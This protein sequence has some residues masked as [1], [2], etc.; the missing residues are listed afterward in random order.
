[1]LLAAIAGGAAHAVHGLGGGGHGPP[2]A[3]DGPAAARRVDARRDE[4]RQRGPVAGSRDSAASVTD[5]TDVVGLDAV[6]D[7]DHGRLVRG[8]GSPV[9][10]ARVGSIRGGHFYDLGSAVW[11]P[12]PQHHAADVGGGFAPRVQAACMARARL[13]RLP[14]A[15]LRA[16]RAVV[17]RGACCGVALHGAAGGTGNSFSFRQ[18]R[19]PEQRS[20]AYDGSM[21]ALHRSHRSA[22]HSGECR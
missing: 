22:G 12:A 20:R 7:A 14:R 17:A 3:A 13:D 18:R 8:R 5:F 1:M 4:R 15:L 10:H 9:E 6:R 21:A 2:D 16:A 19:E 11:G